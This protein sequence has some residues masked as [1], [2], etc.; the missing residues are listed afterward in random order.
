MILSK[1][2]VMSF[3]LVALGFS[4]HAMDSRDAY[5]RTIL[6]NYVNDQEKM[7]T[8]MDKDIDRLWHVCYEIVEIFDG[9]YHNPQTGRITNR[10]K[11]ET[12]RRM[13]CTDQDIHNL[14]SRKNDRALLVSITLA[15]IS[16]M[17][18]SGASLNLKDYN[19]NTVLNFCYTYEIYDR[20]LCLGAE[21]QLSVWIYF[22]PIKTFVGSAALI[23]AIAVAAQQ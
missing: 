17:V 9:V 10:Y 1:K 14:E 3:M 18:N 23:A 21:F 2:M 7:K 22:N 8:I 6:M 13:S 5:G 15:N 20:L 4:A 12:R 16:S 11:D 19:G